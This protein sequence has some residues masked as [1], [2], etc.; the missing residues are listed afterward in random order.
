VYLL[1][2]SAGIT[3]SGGGRKK[4]E[5][6]GMAVFLLLISLNLNNYPVSLTSFLFKVI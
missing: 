3:I 6:Q 1:A 4:F 2:S 5:G